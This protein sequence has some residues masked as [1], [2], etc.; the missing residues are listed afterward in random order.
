MA[1]KKDLKLITFDGDQT[2]YQDGGNFAP[3]H[4][5]AGA[6]IDLLVVRASTHA[7]IAHM[8]ICTLAHIHTYTPV[9]IRT[10]PASPVLHL[11]LTLILTLLLWQSGVHVAVVTAAGYGLD[12]S[13][14]VRHSLPPVSCLCV[15]CLGMSRCVSVNPIC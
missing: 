11:R 3:T 6:I 10:L 8:Q 12:G 7:H 4:E 15:S 5:L 9:H 2:L 14:Y 13:K 1:I